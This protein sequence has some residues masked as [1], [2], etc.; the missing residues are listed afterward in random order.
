MAASASHSASASATAGGYSL[1]L[2]IAY[3]LIAGHLARQLFTA[4]KL[5]GAVAILI[6]GFAGS[7]FMQHELLASRNY[8]QGLAFFV[9]LVRAGTEVD[10]RQAADLPLLM[11]IIL[12]AMLEMTAIALYAMFVYDYEALEAYVL[13][14]ILFCLGDGLVVP[15]ICQFAKLFPG[16]PLVK[17]MM[18]WVPLEATLALTVF[19]ILQGIAQPG[20]EDVSAELL[21]GATILQLTCTTLIGALL[22]ISM[23]F[24]A[25]IRHKILLPSRAKLL[26]RLPRLSVSG[27]L[28]WRITNEPMPTIFEEATGGQPLPTFEVTRD[29]TSS[30]R[31]FDCGASGQSDEDHPHSLRQ[32]SQSSFHSEASIAQ[33]EASSHGS[34]EKRPKESEAELADLQEYIQRPLFSNCKAETLILLLGSCLVAKGLGEEGGAPIGFI[35]HFN[36]FQP[37]L[38]VILTACGFKYGAGHELIHDIHTNLDHVW[39]FGSLVLF[40]MIGSKTDLAVFSKLS[41]V[42]PLFAVGALTR[43]LSIVAVMSITLPMRSCRCKNCYPVS[44]SL[45]LAESTFCFLCTIA[46]ASIQGAIGGVPLTR[47]FFS[48]TSGNKAVRIFI[49]DAAKLAIIF[50][51]LI[52]SVLLEVFGPRLLAHIQ[53][54]RSAALKC[55]VE[56]AREIH[57]EL[58]S[59]GFTN[60]E[61]TTGS[62]VVEEELK[63]PGLRWGVTQKISE[64]FEERI[65]SLEGTVL[66]AIEQAIEHIP[67]SFVEQPLGLLTR[68]RSSSNFDDLPGLESSSSS[69]MELAKYHGKGSEAVHEIAAPAEEESSKS[70]L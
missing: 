40:S 70:S 35:K 63:R 67:I 60:G 41:Q 59:L 50:Y 5:P 43:F 15:K 53:R 14:C 68:S 62:I 19:G 45:I 44:K 13:G 57:K 23:G 27:G 2:G 22:G 10:L 51:A 42:L 46:R 21:A 66:T 8:I 39:V 17:S 37:E 49:A 26:A 54:V 31:A 20:M 7:T 24:L 32:V 18:V 65:D 29:W 1:E 25:R 34:K 9:I 4:M 28:D 61:V 3:F 30:G 56:V 16:H 36:L 47:A 12:P 38:F 33:S 48:E 58:N 11:V 55:E 64:M 69:A 52:G 6:T